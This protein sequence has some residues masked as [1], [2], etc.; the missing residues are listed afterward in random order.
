MKFIF[1]EKN[2]VVLSRFSVDVL[3]LLL[4]VWFVDIFE[5]FSSN[6]D[7]DLCDTNFDFFVLVI[8]LFVTGCTDFFLIFVVVDSTL[9]FL[10]PVPF[11]VDTGEAGRF[12][13]GDC[14]VIGSLS[15]SFSSTVALVDCAGPLSTIL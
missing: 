8:V 15:K 2:I 6:N 7:D 14:R 11:D 4:L 1:H 10:F 3:L 5:T 13:C 9:S 12:C